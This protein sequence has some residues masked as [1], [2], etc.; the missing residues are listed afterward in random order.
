[1]K[2]FTKRLAAFAV[3]G[4]LVIAGVALTATAANAD[5]I[6]GT[7]TLYAKGSGI[8]G[9]A[10]TPNAAK[11]V[12]S[13]SATT[14]PMF[15]GITINGT[16]P[17]GF[18]SGANLAIFQGGNFMGGLATTTDTS[19][20]GNVAGNAGLKSSE[21]S[22]AMDEVSTSG[23]QNNYVDN[24]ALDSIT[25]PLSAG[26]FELRYYCF[27][28]STT[29]D[30]TNDK[31]FTLTL[32]YSV[33]GATHTWSTPVPKTNTTTA[34]TAAADQSAKTVTVATT[35]KDSTGTTALTAAAG[36]ATVNQTAPTAATLGTAT[37]AAGVATFTTGVLAPG[38]YQFTVTYSGDTAYNGSTSGTATSTINGANSGATNITFTVDAGAGG[39]SLTLSNVPASVD[40]G[41]L[42][43]NSGL[44]TGSNATGFKGI[45]VTDTRSI[46]SLPWNLTGQMG[47]FTSGNY[48]LSGNVL[49][50][51][52]A[53]QSGPATAGATVAANTPGLGNAA[54][55][56]T[57]PVTSG[58]PV[59]VVGAALNVAIPANSAT[60]SYTGVLTLTLA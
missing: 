19:V 53:V 54:Q 11:V 46:N 34:I 45:T 56:A 10:G 28:D 32:N 18:R 17:A 4:A 21:T 2:L 23:N 29:P 35:I 26:S 42:A 30:F 37:V 48:T 41:H 22:V 59:S 6:A 20:D 12:T 16:C 55:L 40:L 47:S 44:L 50:W 1:M 36:T 5:Q 39:G 13:G 51:L 43:L 31:Y 8:A 7:I 15:W 27:A 33:S 3:T 25:T 9:G 52:P 58:S 60:G 38:T 14:N 24:K 49:G 57:A